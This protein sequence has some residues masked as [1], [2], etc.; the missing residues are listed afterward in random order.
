MAL[1]TLRYLPGGCAQGAR[2]A[3][4]LTVSRRN[5]VEGARR[6]LQ[7]RMARAAEALRRRAAR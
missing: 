5:S 6:V 3:A 4:H 2:A 1:R 7:R